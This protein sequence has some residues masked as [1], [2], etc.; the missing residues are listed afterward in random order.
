[1]KKK[2]TRIIRKSGDGYIA[3][4]KE[5]P[6]ANTQGRTLSEARSKLKEALTLIDEVKAE[7]RLD[8]RVKRN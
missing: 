6:G 3:Y 2:V 1:M 8:H 7:L 5:I 4:I